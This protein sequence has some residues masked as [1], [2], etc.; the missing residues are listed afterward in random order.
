M[1]APEA[2]ERKLDR[3]LG[4]I[5]TPAAL[6]LLTDLLSLDRADCADPIAHLSPAERRK[7]TFELLIKHLI[8]LAAGPPLVIAFEDIHWADHSS[9][10]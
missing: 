3:L 8:S 1:D 2:R 5:S 10:Y 7:G 6:T 9:I 4:A